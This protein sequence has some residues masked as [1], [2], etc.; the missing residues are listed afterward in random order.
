MHKKPKSQGFGFVFLLAES[1]GLSPEVLRRLGNMNVGE[2]LTVADR[3]G[4]RLNVPNH[5][6]MFASNSEDPH[7]FSDHIDGGTVM[8]FCREYVI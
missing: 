5:Y 3:I 4:A 2:A 8:E 7:L 6:D 1:A